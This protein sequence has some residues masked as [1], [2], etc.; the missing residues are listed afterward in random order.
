M[1]KDLLSE[2]I[3]TNDTPVLQLEFKF[4]IDYLLV[5]LS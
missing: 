4:E 2:H 5:K 1:S 3:Y